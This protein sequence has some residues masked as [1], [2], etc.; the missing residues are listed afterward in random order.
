MPYDFQQFRDD[1]IEHGHILNHL[2][3]PL[4]T[5]HIAP[6]GRMEFFVSQKSRTSFQELAANYARLYEKDSLLVTDLDKP[7]RN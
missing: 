6:W 5:P 2:R 7:A 3:H 4:S 1:R